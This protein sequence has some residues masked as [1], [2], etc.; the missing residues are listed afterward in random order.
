MPQGRSRLKQLGGSCLR[1]GGTVLVL[2]AA[3]LVGCGGS[4][5][6]RTTTVTK[7]HIVTRTQLVHTKPKAA[8]KSGRVP[9]TQQ[10]TTPATTGTTAPASS[11]RSCETGV[12]AGRY[13]SCAF[14]ANVADAYQGQSSVSAYSP[15]TGKTYH[16][17]CSGHG[18]DTVRCVGGNH[19]LVDL[20]P[21]EAPPP[22]SPTTSSP[23]SS[24]A[25]CDTHRCIENFDNGTGYIV[26]CN[27]GMWSHSGGRS[28]ACSDHGGESSRTYP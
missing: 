6:T 1:P 16:L 22:P 3:T 2:V 13:T 23:P 27:D 4:A 14:A 10:P 28:G 19:A 25:F 12:Y 24:A 17:T 9:T 5:Q 18:A 21:A 20:T 15:T 11:Y 8:R 7:T 26:Q